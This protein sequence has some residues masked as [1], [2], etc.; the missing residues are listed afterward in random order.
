MA[1]KRIQEI[2]IDKD[3]IGACTYS[4]IEDMRAAAAVVKGKKKAA[5]PRGP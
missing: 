4:R 1:V 5:S 3:F 2:P